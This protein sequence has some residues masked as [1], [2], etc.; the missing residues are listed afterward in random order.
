MA[1]V[2]DL[3]S[4]TKPSVSLG[5]R[6]MMQISELADEIVTDWV[7]REL[8]AAALRGVARHD[9]A[10]EIQAQPPITAE[11]LEA[12]NGLRRYQ[13][14]L[15]RA[16]F[17]LP[18]KRSAAVPSDDEIDAFIYAEVGAEIF[19]LVHELAADLAFT[20]GDATGA[21]ALQLLRKAYRINPRATAEAIR[22]RY[23]ELFETAVIDGVGRLDMCS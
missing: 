1:R 14:E 21:W 5:G 4:L 10:G 3:A 13:H 12:D 7:V 11:T 22:C 17:A 2:D 19:D 23:H 20:S 16:V 15:Q 18:A 6:N 8:P 9:L